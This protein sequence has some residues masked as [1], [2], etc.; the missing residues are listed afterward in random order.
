MSQHHIWTK[1]MLQL[2]MV[3]LVDPLWCSPVELYNWK[4]FIT[5]RTLLSIYNIWPTSHI[6]STYWTDSHAIWWSMHTHLVLSNSSQSSTYLPLTYLH[7]VICWDQMECVAILVYILAM[8][9]LFLKWFHLQCDT[10]SYVFMQSLVSPHM[11]IIYQLPL[12]R[13]H[14]SKKWF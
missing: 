1:S 2:D 3:V 7:T 8:V 12:H 13:K 10:Y 11:Q 4:N 6:K 9:H 5:S 14:K